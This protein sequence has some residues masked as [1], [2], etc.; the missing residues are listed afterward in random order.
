MNQQFP[1]RILLPALMGALLA[2]CVTTMA[3]RYEQPAAPV[4]AQWPAE[5]R[6]G[7]AG[8]ST[9]TV[10]DLPWE[11]LFA[12][13]KLRQVV[14]LALD[15][16]RDLRVAA[17]NIEKARA[18]YRIQRSELMPNVSVDLSGN[19]G[20]TTYA[21][22]K[23]QSVVGHV[24][25]LQL[26][27]SAW[28]LDLF[29]RIRSLRDQAL[30]QYLSSESAQ[31][32][33]RISLIAEVA[34]AYLDLAAAREQLTVARD[35]ERSRQ[36]AYDLQL[37][38]RETGNASELE[39]LQAEAEL[40]VARDETL[41]LESTIATSRNALELLVGTPLP[42][43]LRPDS[44]LETLLAVQDVPA[45]LPSD[46]LQRR[47]DILA[48]EHTLIAAHA[49]I[50]AARAAFF[51]SISLTG[52]IGRAS[53]SL[54]ELFDSGGRAWSFMPQISVPIFTGGRLSAN[55]DVAKVEREIAVADYERSIQ[56]AFRE[57][58]DA[59]A[60]RAT[61]DGRLAAQQQRVEAAYHAYHLVQQRYD[62]GVAS[63]L[64]VLDSQRTLFSAQQTWISTRLSRQTNLVTLY[65]AL[66][67]GWSPENAQA[68]ALSQSYTGEKLPIAS[69]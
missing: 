13:A 15:N 66:G 58:A 5:S 25:T 53:N 56:A 14:R 6:A 29:G 28:E 12:D 33:T 27:V 1:P 26:G 49:N 8:D 48:A 18:Q 55:L 9:A 60:V 10:A 54:T 35:T 43:A 68:P 69:R 2:G 22:L 65:K 24:Y 46:M 61:L 42:E 37:G 59:L 30:Q 39:V 11:A 31:Q 50:G 45:G 40:Q 21:M 64:E 36:E 17:L 57:V 51:P 32:A 67:G 4:S 23:G 41:V 16:N 62:N 3:P 20:R 63:Y 44:P 47:P 38:L 34:S 7:N 19:N 52:G